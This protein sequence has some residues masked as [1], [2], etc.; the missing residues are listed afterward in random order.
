MNRTQIDESTQMH[1]E[2]TLTWNPRGKQKSGRPNNT[3]RME[4][5]TDMK[6]INVN[7]KGLLRTGLDGEYWCAAYTPPRG[8]TGVSK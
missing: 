7:W 8:A 2:A 4:I 5:E 6:R 1:H 3:L